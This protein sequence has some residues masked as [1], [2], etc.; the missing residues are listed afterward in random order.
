MKKLLLFVPALLMSTG[1][2]ASNLFGP[3]KETLKWVQTGLDVGAQGV[4]TYLSDKEA[5]CT[6]LDASKGADYQVCMKTANKVKKY[7][8]P[9]K[10]TADKVIKTAKDGIADAEKKL[11]HDKVCEKVN[12]DKKSKE[13][14]DCVEKFKAAVMQ[15]IKNVGCVVLTALDFLPDSWKVKVKVWINLLKGFACGVSPTAGDTLPPSLDKTDPTF[16]NG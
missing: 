2:P 14:K 4:N 3:A 5:E 10:A 13:Y 12:P 11:L 9:A 15:H 7:F 6:K 16:L 8:P 1:C